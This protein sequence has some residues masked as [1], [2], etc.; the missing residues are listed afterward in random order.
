MRSPRIVLSSRL[1]NWWSTEHYPNVWY[2]IDIL[3]HPYAIL[4][5]SRSSWAINWLYPTMFIVFI[6]ISDAV[7]K[8]WSSWFTMISHH[9]H[10]FHYLLHGKPWPGP[11]RSVHLVEKGFSIDSIGFCIYIV[12][13]YL[14]WFQKSSKDIKLL[15]SIEFLEPKLVD[16]ELFVNC[17]YQWPLIIVSRREWLDLSQLYLFTSCSGQHC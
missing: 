7:N 12:Y 3:A 10:C 11:S 5:C 2:D 6:I 8:T 17:K 16:E 9:V 13:I 14:L 1:N 4:V 15:W